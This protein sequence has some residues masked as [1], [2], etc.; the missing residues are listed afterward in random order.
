M[1]S[2]KAFAALVGGLGVVAGIIGSTAVAAAVLVAL[3][4]PSEGRAD[5]SPAPVTQPRPTELVVALHLGDPVLQAG[6]VREISVS[7]I[8][9]RIR[10]SCSGVGYPDS[11]PSASSRAR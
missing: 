5:D 11:R 3:G 6:V 8:W 2:R 1:T 10:Q 4:L 7:R 9:E